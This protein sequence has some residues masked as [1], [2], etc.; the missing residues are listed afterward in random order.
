M[1]PFENN[2]LFKESIIKESK[3]LNL[4]IKIIDLQ[5]YTYLYSKA[6]NK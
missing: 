5:Y 4:N 2:F 1:A 3:Y 6:N